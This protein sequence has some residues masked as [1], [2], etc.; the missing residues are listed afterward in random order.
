VETPRPAFTLIE[1]LV[2]IAI[3]A[4]L[5]A[6]LLPAVQQAR[7]A[8][9]RTQ[10]KNNLKQYGLGLHNYH[11]TYGMFPIGATSVGNAAPSGPRVNWQVRLLPYM[12]QAPFSNLINFAS[13]LS[14]MD[15]QMADGRW[16]YQ[17]DVP[18]LHCPTDDYPTSTLFQ[19]QANTQHIMT[20]YAGSMGSQYVGAG[21]AACRVFDS[22]AEKGPVGE[23]G[24]TCNASD[25]S[26]LFGWGCVSVRIR[27]ISDGTSNTLLVGEVLPGCNQLAAGNTNTPS[28]WYWVG[29]PQA[30]ATTITPINEFTSC[31]NARRVTNP[32]CV[33]P[34]PNSAARHVDHARQ[35][36]YGFKS[37]HVGGVQ[38]TLA[39]GSGRFIS[40]N[41][42]HQ[43]Y[44]YVGGKGDGKVIG[45]F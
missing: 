38:F 28:S 4:I 23:R 18:Y 14:A 10:C 13:P 29:G 3:I 25:L 6:L 41:I 19:G 26:G 12:E 45:E 21:L 36:A 15:E 39:D 44:Q 11:D 5:I 35:Y 37:K 30:G 40:E 33:N 27:D 17:I 22:F 20:N 34:R 24:A 32:A 43:L 9:R 7:E 8:A 31:V 1:L 42:N 16:P 2:V